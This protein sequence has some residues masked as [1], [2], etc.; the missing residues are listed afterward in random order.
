MQKWALRGVYGDDVPVM[1]NVEAGGV[2]IH[3][4]D[5]PTVPYEIQGSPM[6]PTE[7][8]EIGNVESEKSKTTVG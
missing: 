4:P 2:V 1:E 3:N 5:R 6:K 8:Q 7:R